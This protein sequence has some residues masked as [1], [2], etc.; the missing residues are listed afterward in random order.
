MHPQLCTYD[1]S[2]NYGHGVWRIKNTAINATL[3]V[4]H[5]KLSFISQTIKRSDFC[6]SY[7]CEFGQKIHFLFQFGFRVKAAWFNSVRTNGQ[8]NRFSCIFFP[9]Y[10]QPLVLSRFLVLKAKFLWWKR[11][12]TGDKTLTTP[13][14]WFCPN[15]LINCLIWW[16]FPE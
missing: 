13:L 12:Y 3:C 9:K 10:P 4:L 2:S 7:N 15:I 11:C 6:C 14:L 5:R 8:R 1:N 16:L